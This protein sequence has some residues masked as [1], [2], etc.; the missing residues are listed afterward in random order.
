MLAHIRRSFVQPSLE[1]LQGRRCHRVS[2]SL[3]QCHATLPRK[4]PFMPEARNPIAIEVSCVNGIFSLS[5]A[6]RLPFGTHSADW[7]DLVLPFNSVNYKPGMNLDGKFKA[8][9]DF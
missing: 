6:R 2:G 9:K 4:K 8:C 5:H 1:N 3:L 7:Y